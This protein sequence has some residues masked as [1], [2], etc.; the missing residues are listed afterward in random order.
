MANKVGKEI[1]ARS[2]LTGDAAC[3]DVR[4][5]KGINLAHNQSPYGDWKSS[6]FH[7]CRRIIIKDLTQICHRCGSCTNSER[8]EDKP[9][10]VM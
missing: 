9:Q 3:H 8:M 2:M 7:L 10:T 4:A 1:G 6:M 5:N